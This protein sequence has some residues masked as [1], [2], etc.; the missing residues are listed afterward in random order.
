MN[1]LAHAWLSFG[2]AEIL[3]GNMISDFVKGKKQFDYPR[4]IR[5]GI[6]LHRA[7]DGFT[8]SHPAT[9]EAKSFFRAAYRLYAG[10]LVDV[11]YDHF[12]ARDPAEFPA[13]SLAAFAEKTYIQLGACQEFFPERWARLFPYMQSHNWLLNYRTKEGIFS[14]FS[15]LARRAAYMPGTQAAN[16]IFEEHYAELEACY[17]NFFPALK[18]FALETLQKL[19][20]NP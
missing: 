5:D 8:D 2:D 3:T 7:I 16:T 4:R 18:E 1:Y 10:P 19:L 15:G 14:S 13:E 6:V 11:A 12:L 17:R 20:N 9:Q